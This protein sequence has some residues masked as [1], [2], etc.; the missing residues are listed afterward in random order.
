MVNKDQIQD[1]T[2]RG[3]IVLAPNHRL[4]PQVNMLEG[5]IQDS[6]NL[7][8]WIHAGELQEAIFSHTETHYPVNLNCVFEFGTSS[9]GT[10]ALCLEDPVPIEGGVSLEGQRKGGPDFSN[11]WQAYVSTQT[12]NGT[13][14]DAVYPSGDLDKVDPIEN[15][16]PSFPPTFIAHGAEDRMVPLH[17]SEALFSALS[18]HGVKSDLRIIPGEDHI[19]AARMKVGSQT[20]NLQREGS[21][22]LEEP[23]K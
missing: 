8:E 7:L 19:F 10:L 12:A 2:D 5:P 16:S 13:V 11:P 3:W 20:W 1:C 17:I 18:Q 22:F 23:I 14:L 4:C 15:L 6:R 9:G 21:D